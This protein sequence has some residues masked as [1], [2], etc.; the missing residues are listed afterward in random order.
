MTIQNEIPSV[1]GYIDD[2]EK[3]FTLRKPMLTLR[4]IVGIAAQLFRWKGRPRD[5]TTAT[6]RD[7]YGLEISQAK[8]PEERRGEQRNKKEQKVYRDQ[9]KGGTVKKQG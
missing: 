5:T 4:C 3:D 7:N 6:I 1:H 8:P 9:K 2:N